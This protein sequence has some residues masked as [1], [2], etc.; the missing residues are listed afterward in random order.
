MCS[1]IFI[2][3][4]RLLKTSEKKL[5]TLWYKLLVI[6]FIFHYLSVENLRNNAFIKI[7]KYLHKCYLNFLVQSYNFVCIFVLHCAMEH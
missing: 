4:P 6:H 5:E 1:A 2:V 7:N 3:K